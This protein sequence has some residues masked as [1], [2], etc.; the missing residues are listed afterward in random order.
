[1]RYR[2]Y[3]VEV[4]QRSRDARAFLATGDLDAALDGLEEIIVTAEQ[5]PGC[6]H[7]A[8]AMQLALVA[9]LLR[10]CKSAPD[11]SIDHY[12]RVGALSSRIEF[13]L[14]SRGRPESAGGGASSTQSEG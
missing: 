12:L 8:P 9:T 5:N 2:Q 6:A 1:V 7:A 14:H 4:T 13:L 10:D 3:Q 11:R